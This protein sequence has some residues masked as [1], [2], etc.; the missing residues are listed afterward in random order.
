[1]TFLSLPHFNV[2]CSVSFKRLLLQEHWVECDKDKFVNEEGQER[3]FSFAAVTRV[4]KNSLFV[5]LA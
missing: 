4:A 5:K 1:M 3:V 2:I